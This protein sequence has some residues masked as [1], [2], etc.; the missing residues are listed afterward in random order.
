[1]IFTTVDSSDSER[2]AALD[3]MLRVPYTRTAMTSAL[4]RRQLADVT[5]LMEHVALRLQ[6]AETELAEALLD[7]LT[8]LLDS[9]YASLA[10]SDGPGVRQLLERIAQWRDRQELAAQEAALLLRTLDQ[11]TALRRDP[12][13]P[14]AADYC[15][16]TLQL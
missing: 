13:S 1:M 7:W 5:R 10:L 15:V 8:V 12:P 9:Q 14:P 3:D 6:S 16:E 4:R 11:V 2:E